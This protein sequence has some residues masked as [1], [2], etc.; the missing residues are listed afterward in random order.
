VAGCPAAGS[1]RLRLRRDLLA[2]HCSL[3]TVALY[4][5]PFPPWT[6]IWE[7]YAF[8]FASDPFVGKAPARWL[9]EAGRG[10]R[11]S[12]PVPL[13]ILSGPGFFRR[14]SR[15]RNLIFTARLWLSLVESPAGCERSRPIS[16]SGS[17]LLDAVGT[18]GTPAGRPRRPWHTP[19]VIPT[20]LAPETGE[21]SW[22]CMGLRRVP[23]LAEVLFVAIEVSGFVVRLRDRRP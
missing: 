15:W 20:T 17:F 22:A 14:P 23:F 3:L 19:E 16:W 2:H 5:A 13:S 7:A 6:D 4:K 9:V 1:S 12:R 11:H 8:P 10:G 21:V 18:P